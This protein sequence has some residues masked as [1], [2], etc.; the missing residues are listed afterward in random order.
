[1][2]DVLYLGPARSRLFAA[3]PEVEL[4]RSFSLEK[5]RRWLGKVAAGPRRTTM[6]RRLR[7]VV[8]ANGP[9]RPRRL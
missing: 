1:L 6:E 2:L 8:R 7:E 5:A 3:L 4:P 9:G